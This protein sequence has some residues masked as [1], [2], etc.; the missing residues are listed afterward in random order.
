MRSPRFLPAA[1]GAVALS[2]LLGGL[3]AGDVATAQ[4]E[5][6][7]QYRIYTDALAKVE[8]EYVEAVP[9]ERLVYS[10]IDGLLHT[11]DPHS[12]FFEPRDYAAMRER[13]SGSYAGLGVTIASI[14]GDITIQS[15]FEGSPAY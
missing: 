9:V 2:A 4:D 11:L 1:L 15:I 13:Q 7:R 10:S 12:S 6:T 8:S 14:D 3:V 5:V